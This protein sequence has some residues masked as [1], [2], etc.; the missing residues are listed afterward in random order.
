[1]L[2]HEHR[3]A[4]AATAVEGEELLKLRPR[5]APS[6][7]GLGGCHPHRLLCPSSLREDVLHLPLTDE[8]SGWAAGDQQRLKEEKFP[9]RS[10][11]EPTRLATNGKT[12][13]LNREGKASA[14]TRPEPAYP[15]VAP[16]LR[17]SLDKVPRSLRELGRHYPPR[18]PTQPPFRCVC[19]H[20]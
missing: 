17:S 5:V 9:L 10:R 14:A 11:E 12:K 7:T 15:A 20:R 4:Q 6:L 2:A 8:Q 19:F 13:I 1:M 18:T 16:P 3:R